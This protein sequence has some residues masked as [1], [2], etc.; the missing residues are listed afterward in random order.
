MKIKAL[1]RF[2]EKLAS[3]E[4][5]VGI[6]I[7]LEAP[8]LTEM[9]VALDLDYVVID[10]EH[11]HLGWKEIAEHVRATVR[12]KT[13]AI[14]R[15]QERDTAITKRILDIGADGIIVPGIETVEQIEEALS[16][17]RYPPEGRR[18]IGGERA[19]TWGQS[20]VEH[21][22]EANEHVLVVPLVESV[23]G[24]QNIAQFCQVEGIEVFYFGPAD[25]SASAGFRGEWEGP[26]VTEQI[27]EAKDI[28]RASGKHCGLIAK[29]NEDLAQRVEQGF[30]MLGLGSD[31][32]M[33]LNTLH[34]RL[35]TLGVDRHPSASLDPNDAEPIQ[36]D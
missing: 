30:R 17:C 7:T 22:N 1:K 9:A 5:V 6:W 36:D 15:I 13:V 35:K 26:G 24:A 14:V 4:P 32:S 19:T 16:D 8:S 23:T 10:T 34:G 21:T 12:S 18:G 2:R 11:G 20:I 3:D 33:V 25:F 28:I 31:A 29:S 27:L